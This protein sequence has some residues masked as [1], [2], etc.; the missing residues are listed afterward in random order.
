[1][2]HKFKMA[3]II[4]ENGKKIY[5]MEHIVWKYIHFILTSVAIVLIN[6]WGDETPKAP[7]YLRVKDCHKIKHNLWDQP[8]K[9]IILR[10]FIIGGICINSYNR[11]MNTV[12][13]YFSFKKEMEFW[14]VLWGAEPKTY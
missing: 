7:I 11:Y 14:Y 10:S 6:R 1:M 12:E 2:N 13:Y 9:G 4:R 3:V 8:G 5:I